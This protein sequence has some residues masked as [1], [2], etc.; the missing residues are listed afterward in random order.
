MGVGSVAGVTGHVFISYSHDGDGAYVERLAAFLTQRGVRVWFD[1]E[2]I[3]GDRWHEVIQER[4]DSCAALIVVMSPAAQQSV[5]VNREITQA[6]KRDKAI[7]P[8]LRSGEG[9]FRLGDVQHEDVSPDQ[10]PSSEFVER[11]RRHQPGPRSAAAAPVT[12]ASM[13]AA[14]LTQQYDDAVKMYTRGD[15]QGAAQLLRHVVPGRIR[16]LG[17]DHPHTLTS[18]HDLAYCIGESRDW[19]EAVRLFQ[20]VGADRSRVLGADHPHTLTSWHNLAY[21]IGEG[22]NRAEA[23]RVSRGVVA[24]RTRVLGADHPDTL[25]SRH[26]LALNVGEGGNPAEAVRLYRGVVADRARVLGAYHPHTLASRHNLAVNV[27]VGGDRAESVRL[28]RG[29]VADRTR[30][31]GAD[32]PDTKLSQSWL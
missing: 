13:D 23:V 6:E 26:V 30:V 18:R 32:H 9:F 24:D 20:G 2:I 4:I 27:G 17:P 11:L 15:Y 21:Y 22:G 19:A 14:T 10:M 28:F 31:L 3:S 25:T 12:T 8:L 29:L 1:R 7:F 5:W 16:V